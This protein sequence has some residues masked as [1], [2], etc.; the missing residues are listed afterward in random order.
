MNQMT[1]HS[2]SD[3]LRQRILAAAR[4]RFSHEGYGKTTM[5]D[6]AADCQC[7]PANLYR[8]YPS[9]QDIAA[10]VCQQCVSD[11][12]A[13]LRELV[14]QPGTSAETRLRAYV[15][16][17]LKL[18]RED[19]QTGPK[20]NEFIG[21]ILEKRQDLVHA[22]IQAQNSLIV[23]ILAFGNESGEFE[24]EDVIATARSVYASL[25]LFEVPLFQP[26]YSEDE[27]EV[28]ANSTVDLLLKG[29]GRR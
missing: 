1:Q 20:L 18:S 26:L 13:T 15:L 3:E 2:D 27:F 10:A 28:L 14:R 4:E 12:I 8:Y 29:L 19:A 16:G 11:S 9:K 6:L 7:S 25:T 17:G 22:R 23:E 24:V 5:A 21:Y